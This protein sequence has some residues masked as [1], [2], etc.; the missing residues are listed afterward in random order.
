MAH[1]QGED[2]SRGGG[3][4]GSHGGGVGLHVAA[5]G[6]HLRHQQDHGQD[7]QHAGL[8]PARQVRRQALLDGELHFKSMIMKSKVSR[9]IIL[10]DFFWGWEERFY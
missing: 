7:A 2:A 8:Q 4:G 1:L 6:T 3:P 10:I 9:G 5:L